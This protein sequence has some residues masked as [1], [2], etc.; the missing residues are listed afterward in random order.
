MMRCILLISLFLRLTSVTF[1]AALIIEIV[2]GSA[3]SQFAPPPD[4]NGPGSSA[5]GGSRLTQKPLQAIYS[6][7][8]FMVHTRL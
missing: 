8:G 5:G 1:T 2:E 3:L 6:L 7:Q 4:K